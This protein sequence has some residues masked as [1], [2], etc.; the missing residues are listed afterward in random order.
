[1]TVP[2]LQQPVL[3]RARGSVSLGVARRGERHVVAE[4][5]QSGCGRLLFPAIA[6]GRPL[7]AVVVNT[8]G[9]LTGGD[10]FDAALSLAPGARA[11]ATTQAC[12]KIYR[13]D[14]S[15]ALVET[16]LSLAEGASLAWLPQETILFDR[17]RLRRRLT[18]EMT[19][20]ARLLAME[21]VLLG[22]KASGES[23]T[24]GLFR[25]SWRVRRAGKLVFAEETAFDGD[26]AARLSAAATLKGAA[27]Y[28][29]VLLVVPDAASHLQ[30]AR[31]VL[32]KEAA[33]GG[34]STFERL[35]VARVIAED[36]A[37][38]RRVLIPLLGALGGELPRVW[39]T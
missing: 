24:Q 15:D 5:A 6:A 38:L 18:V 7:E 14:G 12:E 25:D 10:R 21:A 16:R 13:S 2:A 35:C 20:D 9:G 26:L 4:L 30:A 11:L 28:A 34:I 33:E 32:T 29:T 8:S 19:E 39:H 17:A 22:R 3:E 27:A 37:A 31:D 1:M 23:L 36:G